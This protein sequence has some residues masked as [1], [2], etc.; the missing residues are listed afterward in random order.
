MRFT[1]TRSMAVFNPFFS[2]M[3][4]FFLLANTRYK[5]PSLH[6]SPA[7]S[8]VCILRKNRPTGRGHPTQDNS[9]TV[10]SS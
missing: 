9:L 10:V 5:H 7:L 8:F 2:S 3:N 6:R 1:F 4:G